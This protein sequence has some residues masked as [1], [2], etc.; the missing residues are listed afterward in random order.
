MRHY[1]MSV[2]YPH[3]SINDNKFL[4][5][6]TAVKL[7]W[8]MM[9]LGKKLWWKYISSF[10]KSK[11]Y[12]KETKLSP[13]SIS[14]HYIFSREYC[15]STHITESK[16]YK[17]LHLKAKILE[18]QLRMNAIL[19]QLILLEIRFCWIFTNLHQNILTKTI[20]L[21]CQK[22]SIFSSIENDPY[23][24]NHYSNLSILR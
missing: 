23:N 7:A 12:T 19:Y 24:S 1:V 2:P 22:K 5:P 3:I 11:S 17:N 20:K 4:M 8:K 14:N 15:F 21:C 18:I 6:F 13:L 16:S 9:K 10:D